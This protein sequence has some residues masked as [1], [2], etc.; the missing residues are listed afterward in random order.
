MYTRRMS[1][2]TE[3]KESCSWETDIFDEGFE[4]VIVK[5]RGGRGFQVPTKEEVCARTRREINLTGYL[6]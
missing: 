1:F 6:N 2:R 5:Q 4:K 3:E